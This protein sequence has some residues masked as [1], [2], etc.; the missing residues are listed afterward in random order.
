MR[1]TAYNL[2]DGQASIKAS[3][4]GKRVNW[5]SPGIW[6]ARLPQSPNR[7]PVGGLRETRRLVLSAHSCLSSD[8]DA[9]HPIDRAFSLALH[10]SA[11][12]RCIV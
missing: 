8:C 9:F 5:G 4:L 6:T 7:I 10:Y 1:A 2:A 12:R 3:G 11:C